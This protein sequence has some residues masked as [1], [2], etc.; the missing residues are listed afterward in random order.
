MLLALALAPDPIRCAGLRRLW[1]G[2]AWTWPAGQ[3]IE[4]QVAVKKKARQPGNGTFCALIQFPV[5]VTG[6]GD[7]DGESRLVL[8]APS[9]HIQCDGRMRVMT[10][11]EAN[12]YCNG[13][14]ID[15]SVE[16]WTKLLLLVCCVPDVY[17]PDYR[18]AAAMTGSTTGVKMVAFA[19][20]FTVFCSSTIYRELI[21]GL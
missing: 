8:A 3:A 12:F 5:T 2:P 4:V 15:W 17:L 13:I 6:S 9:K 14:H 21:D 7:G 20:S 18:I 16:R 1:D 10:S 11:I 19:F